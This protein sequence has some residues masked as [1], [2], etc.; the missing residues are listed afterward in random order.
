M[1]LIEHDDA[2]VPEGGVGE[3]A[4]AEDA[5]GDEG[6]AGLGAADVLEADLVADGLAD[7]LANLLGDALGGEAGGEPPGLEDDNLL[8]LTES[9]LQER[10]GGPGRL[11]GAGR[12]LQDEGPG[13]TQRGDDL[14]EERIDREGDI[15]HGRSF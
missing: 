7:A 15:S 14:R 1:E 4:A 12:G 13:A 10:A 2:D 5:L 6:Q 3:E 11:A 9:G 8:G